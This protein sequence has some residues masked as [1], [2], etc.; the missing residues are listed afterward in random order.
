MQNSNAVHK[1][2]MT[3]ITSLLFVV[4]A[5]FIIILIG[6]LSVS[7]ILPI[8]QTIEYSETGLK[9]IQ[10]WVQ[11][12]IVI[13]LILPAIVWVVWFRYSE[14]RTIFGFYLLL[15]I[16]QIITEQIISSVWLQ[17]LV[18][19][20]GTFYTTFR[21]W[22]L[23]QGLQ[24]IKTIQKQS[25]QKLVIGTLW[26]LLLFWSSNLIVLLALAWPSIL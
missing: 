8:Q 11:L 20:V 19:V 24:L 22:Q 23:W 15:L 5:T 3:W 4:L 25:R 14:P 9:F 7:G 6:G 17:S 16:I 26:L 13:G 12:A 2:S 18:V 10:W 21:V 1:Q